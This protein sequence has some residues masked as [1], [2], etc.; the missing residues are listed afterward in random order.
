MNYAYEK[1]TECCFV[2]IANSRI[3][4]RVLFKTQKIK[5]NF[6][7]F[8][9]TVCI[10]LRRDEVRNGFYLKVL[11]IIWNINEILDLQSS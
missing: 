1:V 3:I 7:F 2:I 4:S 6:E 9:N 5:A 8:N 10:C 11:S